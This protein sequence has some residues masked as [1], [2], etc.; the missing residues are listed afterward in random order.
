MNLRLCLTGLACLTLAGGE[1]K[2]S[3]WLTDYPQALA[4]A[5]SV[6][7]PLFVVFRCEH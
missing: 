4:V 7:K 1:S 5:R 2:R 6:N 3:E